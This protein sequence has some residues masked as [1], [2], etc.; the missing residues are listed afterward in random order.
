[1][2]IEQLPA[3]GWKLST[4]QCGILWATKNGKTYTAGMAVKLEKR[5]EQKIV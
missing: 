5:D 4:D 3:K 1:M 2:T